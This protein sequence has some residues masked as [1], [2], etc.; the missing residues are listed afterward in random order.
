[1]TKNEF[2]IE[3]KGGKGGFLSGFDPGIFW[4]INKTEYF[5]ILNIPN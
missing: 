4:N 1:V 5:E 2:D 3:N